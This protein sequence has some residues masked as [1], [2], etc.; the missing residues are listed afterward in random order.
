MYGSGKLSINAKRQATG[1]LFVLP[2]FSIFLIFLI[3]PIGFTFYLSFTKW[4]GFKFSEIKFVG[5]ANFVN[6][7]QDRIFWR[8]LKN[9]II[10][11]GATT[12]FLNILGLSFALIIDSKVRGSRVCKIIYFLPVVMCPVVIGIMWSRL[13][14]PFGFVNQLLGRVGL[15]RLTHPWLGEAKYALF[16]VVMATVW[17]WMAYDMVIYYAGLQD[18]PVELHEVASLDGASYWQRLRYVTLPLL[19]PVTT[20]IVLLNLIGGIKVFDMIFVMTGGGP[21][22]HSEVLSTYLYSQGFTYNFM[23]YAS[24]IGVIIVLLSFTTAYFRLRVSYEAV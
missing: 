24:A 15:E 22:Y 4:M 16:A 17:Q 7:F 9:T 1:F 13:L 11:V 8:A 19:R 5:L 18:I 6:L 10:Y 12:L 23:G 2:A 3:Y 20:M 21:N 14:D